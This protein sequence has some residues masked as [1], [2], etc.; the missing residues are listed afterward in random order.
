MNINVEV[1]RSFTFSK[2]HH[3]KT[4]LQFT[5]NRNVETKLNLQN[6]FDYFVINVPGAI[7]LRRTLNRRH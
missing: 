3:D 4:K 1:R 6:T 2:V 5:D 7:Y